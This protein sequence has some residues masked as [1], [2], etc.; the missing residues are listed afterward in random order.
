MATELLRHLL[1]LTLA[2]SLGIITALALR[3]LTRRLF[4]ASA[5]YSLWLLVPIAMLSV[6]LPQVPAT[7]SQS[8]IASLS[9]TST[10]L[11]HVVGKP[12]ESL[13]TAA[14][15]PFYGAPWTVGVWGLGVAIFA[16]YLVAL[17]RAF[18]RS[19]GTLSG[20][21]C[22]RRAEHSVGCPALI[23]VLRPKV[24][25]PADFR[26]R[27]TRLERLLVLS[28]ERT[29]LRRGDAGWNALVALM[30]CIFWFNPLIHVAAR[31]FRFDQ[32]LACDAAVL[33]ARRGSRR[34]YATAMLK[35]QLTEG[36]LPIGCHWR[37][38]Q[39]LKER[40]RMVS[41]RA[42]D[43]T[44]RRFGRAL[45]MF[46]AGIVAYTAWAEQPVAGSTTRP[47]TSASARPHSVMGWTAAWAGWLTS[48]NQA[49][50]EPV[51]I[52]IRD[53]RL[54][55]APGV[56]IEA[57]ADM[58]GEQE[59]H[60]HGHVSLRAI[61][62]VTDERGGPQTLILEGHAHLTFTSPADGQL[63]SQT[64]VVD[65]NRAVLV[66]HP[67][68]ESVVQVDAATMQTVLVPQFVYSAKAQILP[69]LLTPNSITPNLK[70]ADI[71]RVAAAVS[72]ATHRTFVIDPRV[73][74]LLTMVSTAPM[75]PEAF[76]QAFL[77]ILR[78]GGF[79]AMPVG[80]AANAV[81]IVPGVSD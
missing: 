25:L 49:P 66:G 62:A 2:S 80:P 20:V 40:L 50:D 11:T 77:D 3:A 52:V 81:K 41:R 51:S 37:S 31:Y 53:A 19:L 44:R 5:S 65:S 46:L 29:H 21:R 16:V 35:T 39:D 13:V 8:P 76:Y 57:T 1:A 74:G 23:G 4:G 47:A 79:V 15:T 30:R 42:P 36:A 22:V 55:L 75:T 24:I 18:V 26:V 48:P 10:P 43:R 73:H 72:M 68:G 38:A 33:A 6:L 58:A 71:S 60:L 64:T 69:Q 56:I 9:V 59:S 14:A 12:L 32:E 45:T 28:H 61:G 54:F 63:S 34:P 70:D 78:T 7:G 67:D 17:Q 27:Y